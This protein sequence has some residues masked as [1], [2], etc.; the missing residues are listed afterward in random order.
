[1]AG[2]LRLRKIS[3]EVE[4]QIFRLWLGGYTY[5]KISLECGG[6]SLATI[7]KVVDIARKRAPD[8]DELRQLNVALKKGDRSVYDAVRGGN[9]LDKVNQLGVGLEDLE[10]YIKTAERI[11]SEKE[12]EAERFVDS[13]I[14]LIR[15]E[16]ETG[17]AYLD[18]IKDFEEKLSE[19]EKLEE[20]VV[21]LEG[22]IQKLTDARGQ[23][24]D[25]L[26]KD[27]TDLTQIGQE[28]KS[29]V[30]TKE[31]FE[32]LGLEK[33]NHLAEF[34][35]DFEALGFNAEMVRDLAKWRESLANMGIDPN[36]LKRF[37]EEKG[38]LDKQLSSLKHKVGSLKSVIKSLEKQRSS[39]LDK[40]DVL[41]EVDRI[42]EYKTTFL[43]CKDCGWSMPI[44]L[45]TGKFYNSLIRERRIITLRCRCEYL[46][47]FDPRTLMIHMGW[48]LLPTG[49]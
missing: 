26:T 5:R 13:T 37:V 22:D 10:D 27:K 3:T 32:R 24:E 23:L 29:T 11:S 18:V 43:P 38:P 34:I 7:S 41:S 21:G 9:L 48:M 49:D 16:A 1:M 14:R 46:N 28:L 6:V 8:I 12:V 25:K 2:G 15:L 39:L 17:K 35:E 30:A 33:L 4:N 31:R 36:G 20:K 42:L 40:N 44:K 47:R 45:E 19:T